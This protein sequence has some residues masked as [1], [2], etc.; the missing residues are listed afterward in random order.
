MKKWALKFLLLIIKELEIRDG[1]TLTISSNAPTGSGLGGSSSMGCVVYRSLC[2]HF[3][4][5]FD[6]HEAISFIQRVESKILGQGPAGYQDYYPA[7]FGGILALEAM[8]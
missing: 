8:P 6:P 5:N 7:Y 3:N 4:F 2:Q 1:F